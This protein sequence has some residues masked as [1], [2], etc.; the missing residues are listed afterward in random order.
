M[1]RPTW[2]SPAVAR[3]M[4]LRL[5]G[6]YAPVTSSST[7]RSRAI[8][9]CS[10]HSAA[11][12][13]QDAKPRLRDGPWERDGLELVAVR[14]EDE[15]AEVGGHRGLTGAWLSGARSAPGQGRR[16]KGAHRR[17]AARTQGDVPT[18]V[19]G[20]HCQVCAQVEPQLGI[21]LAETD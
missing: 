17:L 16:M 2:R 10:A 3:S 5:P 7:N 20:R 9:A 12:Q 13:G 1:G 19:G 14:I 11:E 8:G 18:G 15:G 6:R 4:G 21:F